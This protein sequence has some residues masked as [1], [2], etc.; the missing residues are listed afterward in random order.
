MP[1][2]KRGYKRRADKHKPE[3][4]TGSFELHYEDVVNRNRFALIA[5]FASGLVLVA[6]FIPNIVDRSIAE[7][8]NVSVEAEHG[9]VVNP[10]FVQMVDG[11]AT[12]SE[13]SYIEFRLT[14]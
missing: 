11:D 8:E 1:T 3:V 5:L 2:L 14:P 7:H 6:A 10:S 4:V 12:A 13:D 9:T